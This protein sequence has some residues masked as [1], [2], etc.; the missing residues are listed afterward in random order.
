[1]ALVNEI[2][3]ST[4]ERQKLHDETTCLSS[5]FTDDDGRRYIQLD[6]YGSKTRQMANKVS[7][8]IQLSEQASAQLKKLIESTY[9]ELK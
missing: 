6:T 1:M 3:K 4:K 2:T 9:P 8:S 5:V 7:Q